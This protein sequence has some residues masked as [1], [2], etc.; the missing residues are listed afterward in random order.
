MPLFK[1][2]AE[3][4]VVTPEPEPVVEEESKKEEAKENQTEK[5]EETP[6]EIPDQDAKIA[7][8]TDTEKPEETN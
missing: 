1:V 5:K 7:E 4:H 6:E 3:H 8:A 2:L